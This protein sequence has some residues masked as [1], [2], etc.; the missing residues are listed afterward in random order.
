MG[1]LPQSQTSMNEVADATFVSVSMNDRKASTVS[2][3]S[4][5]E[6]GALGYSCIDLRVFPYD[7]SN[8]TLTARAN[9]YD[10]GSSHNLSLEMTE[11][12]SPVLLPKLPIVS[13]YSQNA[14]YLVNARNIEPRKPE[15]YALSLLLL[16]LFFTAFCSAYTW[17]NLSVADFEGATDEAAQLS[18]NEEPLLEPGLL[19]SHTLNDYR[20]RQWQSDIRMLQD[21]TGR[22]NWIEDFKFENEGLQS[23]AMYSYNGLLSSRTL[24][25]YRCRQQR[26]LHVPEKEEQKSSTV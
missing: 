12:A 15:I 22:E 14:H 6:D 10:L 23:A 7:T 1:I 3:V 18:R 8:D 26:S 25:E 13:T 19:T 16:L 2:R 20:Y 17:S 21:I 9:V 5:Q 4:S 24:D 11:K